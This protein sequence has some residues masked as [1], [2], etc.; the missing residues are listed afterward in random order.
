MGA[1][2]YMDAVQRSETIAVSIAQT[3]SGELIC[4]VFVSF[5]HEYDPKQIIDEISA[6]LELEGISNTAIKLF[7]QHLGDSVL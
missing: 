6:L 1:K 2:E 5:I 3:N 4:L 7:S